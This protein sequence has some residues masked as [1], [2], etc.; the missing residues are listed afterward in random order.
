MKKLILI[1]LLF[2][3]GCYPPSYGLYNYQPVI[4]YPAYARPVYYQYYPQPAGN[5]AVYN[6][7]N[8]FYYNN[9]TRPKRTITIQKKIYR[10][11]EKIFD[12]TQPVKEEKWAE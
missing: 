1:V 4:Y 7:Q 3:P 11:G 5:Y 2:L 12:Q 9:V 6:G 10:N 8:N